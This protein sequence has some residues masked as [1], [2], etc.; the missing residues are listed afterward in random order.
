MNV[1]QWI[2]KTAVL[3]GVLLC[4]LIVS[5]CQYTATP[6][7]LLL[8]PRSTPENAELASAVRDHL[9]ARA[10][11]SLAMQERSN[12]AVVKMDA[13]GDGK[14]EAFVIYSDESGTEHVMVLKRSA[15]IGWQQWF[16]F[17]ETSSYGID[18][19]RTVDLDRDGEPEVLIGW[20][21]YGEPQHILTL[22]HVPATS[23][24]VAPKP[25][26][27]LPYDTLGVGDAE[28][29]GHDE[30]ALIQLQR[31]KLTASIGI[32]HFAGDR[33]TKMASAALDGTVNEYLQVKLGKIAKDKY[34]V[35]ADAAIGANSSMTTMYAWEAGKL[36]SIYPP[37]QSGDENVQINATMQL[38][39][40]GNGDGILDV[41]ELR[42]APGQS[43]GVAYSD[44]LW[45][46]QYKQWNGVDGF[47]VVGEQYVDTIRSYALSLPMEWSHYTFRRLTDGNSDDV[48]LDQFDEE[49]NRREGILALRVI[50]IAEWNNKEQQL[51]EEGSRFVQLGSGSGLV[52][53][54]IWDAP[55]VKED[56]EKP[57]GIF[58]PDEATMRKLFK[59]LPES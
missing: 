42:E 8:N 10:K 2:K 31:Q 55:F 38:S 11:L 37:K 39:D 45:I 1:S 58:P 56:T 29:D 6:A 59:L 22:Y 51:Q 7:D 57:S 5:G 52:Y 44:L 40:D 48:A 3:A 35:L 30:L 43:E 34:G 13:D 49:T 12:S 21:Q 25:I 19:L 23:G 4:F 46:Q 27:E 9:P 54:A 50:P 33:V 26:A 15:D 24:I 14:Q 32:Y 41:I 18:V 28:G 20:N 47:D 17:D 53:V 36:V 16:T